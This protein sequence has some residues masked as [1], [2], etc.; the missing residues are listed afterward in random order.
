MCAGVWVWVCVIMLIIC[1]I[2]F[3]VLKRTTIL[4]EYT[5]WPSKRMNEE[6]SKQCGGGGCDA[7]HV[8]YT[9]QMM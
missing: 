3:G 6:T 7:T 2:F 4:T 5:T 1:E 8:K 9:L